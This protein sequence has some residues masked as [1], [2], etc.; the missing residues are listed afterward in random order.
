VRGLAIPDE[1]SAGNENSSVFC[2]NLT[3]FYCFTWS[4]RYNS[5]AAAVVIVSVAFHPSLFCEF[6]HAVRD[7]YK[8][9][10]K[11]GDTM[12]RFKMIETMLNSWTPIRPNLYQIY[13]PLRDFKFDTTA[14]ESDLAHFN[15]SPI[16]PRVELIWPCLLA[17]D[18]VL[19]VASTAE[20]ASYAAFSAL[21]LIA[22]LRYRDERLFFTQGGDPRLAHARRYRLIA[23]TDESLASLPFGVIVHITDTAFV[24][25]EGVREQF[26][27]RTVRIYAALLGIMD[28]KLLEDPYY[29]IRGTSIDWSE[30][31]LAGRVTTNDH[32][33]TELQKTE[34]FRQWRTKQILRSSTRTGFLST[35]PIEAIDK[36]APE[37][38]AH[39]LQ[40]VRMLMGEN[41]RDRHFMA[42]LKLHVL[43]LTR[44]MD[45]AAATK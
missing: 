19:I 26:R 39:C 14:I 33:L 22:P 28:L 31:G 41:P 8:D 3:D 42:V 34:T 45:A 38:W 9:F 5:V 16:L 7:F 12:C 35:L 20:V 30:F 17:N 40:S 23:T 13:Y 4:F 32:L 6:L 1:V 15:L 25:V 11:V 36:L 44:R 2:F 18:G 21:S 24:P 27:A 37:E 43:E 10:T 29:D